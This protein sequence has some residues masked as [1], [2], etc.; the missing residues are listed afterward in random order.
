MLEPLEDNQSII[1]TNTIV[2][3]QFC[4]CAIGLLNQI[5]SWAITSIAMSRRALILSLVLSEISRV[6]PNSASATFFSLCMRSMLCRR[7]NFFQYG[8]RHKQLISI[9]LCD[10]PNPLYLLLPLL[11]RVRLFNC[12]N[13]SAPVRCFGGGSVILVLFQKHFILLRNAW[14][15]GRN[16][17]WQSNQ[18]GLCP[19]FKLNVLMSDP[20]IGQA[21]FPCV[22]QH[23]TKPYPGKS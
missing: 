2:S 14:L 12:S 3:P 21:S 6:V 1:L 17:L 7:S 19:C 16:L 5:K 13:I 9:Q 15:A 10:F 4:P 22:L 23:A 11:S 18:Q 8:N 20:Q